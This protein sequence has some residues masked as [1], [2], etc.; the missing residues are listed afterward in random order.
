MQI[1]FGKMS[2]NKRSVAVIGAGKICFYIYI[3]IYIFIYDFLLAP[4]QIPPPTV[5]Q[6]LCS[7]GTL[8]HPESHICIAISVDKGTSSLINYI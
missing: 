8:F 5:L 6:Y 2:E 7:P 4:V 1:L 3:Y